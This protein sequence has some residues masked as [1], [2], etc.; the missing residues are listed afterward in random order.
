[1]GPGQFDFDVS[2]IKSTKLWEHGT[3]EFHVDAF[4]I[5][6]HPQFNEP[7]NT[8]ISTVAQ[9]GQITS[10]SVTPRVFQFGLKYIF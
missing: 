8:A 10:A 7:Y 2:L 3:L 6:N 1:M 4:N 5:F 9:F